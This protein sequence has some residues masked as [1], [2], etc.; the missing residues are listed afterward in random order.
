M[1]A[2]IPRFTTTIG[3]YRQYHSTA[4]IKDWPMQGFMQELKM[5]IALLQKHFVKSQPKTSALQ[6]MSPGFVKTDFEQHKNEEMNNSSQGME[7][8]AIKSNSHCERRNYAIRQPNDVVKLVILL[9]VVK[10]KID[11]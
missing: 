11:T 8:V 9:F 10:T 5:P 6:G 7:Q 1:S 3:T 4:G 2:A